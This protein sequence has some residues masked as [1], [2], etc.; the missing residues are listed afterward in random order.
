[1]VSVAVLVSL[2]VAFT[3]TPMLSSRWLRA[4]DEKLTLEGSLLRKGLYYFNHF[5]EILSEKYRK[6]IAW[7]LSHRKT[8]IFGSIGVFLFSFVL[9]RFLGT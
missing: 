1:M 6:A 8:V 3:L 2:F 5:F 9:I 4:A 7:S